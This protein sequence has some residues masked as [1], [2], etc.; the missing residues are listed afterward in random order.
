MWVVI[1]GGVAYFFKDKLIAF[2][3]SVTSPAGTPGA[4]MSITPKG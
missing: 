1:I 2:Y 4:L 3:H